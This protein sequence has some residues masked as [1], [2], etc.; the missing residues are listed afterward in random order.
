MKRVL[1]IILVF[2]SVG[3]RAQDKDRVSSALEILSVHMKEVCPKLVYKPLTPLMSPPKPI[4]AIE[5]EGVKED[6]YLDA[7]YGIGS[8]FDDRYD[9]R[10][11]HYMF[12]SR[13]RAIKYSA[14]FDVVSRIKEQRGIEF[15]QKGYM[16]IKNYSREFFRQLARRTLCHSEYYLKFGPATLIKE[17]EYVVIEIGRLYRSW[18]SW[19]ADKND[20]WS[21]IVEFN[22]GQ[23][24]RIIYNYTKKYSASKPKNGPYQ[25]YSLEE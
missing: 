1:C 25:Y 5:L 11:Y 14:A 9:K 4:N 8:L 20:Y 2:I 3:M 17:N 7:N 16:I 13:R 6:V 19:N 12:Q 18:F 23:P 22:K 24:K 10:F 15:P 21:F